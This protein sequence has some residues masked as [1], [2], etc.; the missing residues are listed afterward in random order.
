MATILVVDDRA[1]N[2]AFLSTL[3]GYAGYTIVEA[4]DAD[5]GLAVALEHR[6]D[7]VIA[8]ILMPTTDGFD[9]VRQLR[10][11]P[12]IA[13]TR[14]IFYTATYV[15]DEARDLARAVGVEHLLTKPAEPQ[16]ILATVQSVLGTTPAMPVAAATERQFERDHQRLLL[17]K[18]TQ[19]VDELESINADLEH[20]VAERTAELAELTE[21]LRDMNRQ[22]DRL[23][24]IVA[25]DLRSPLGSIQLMADELLE[26]GVDLPEMPHRRFLEQIRRQTAHLSHLISNLLN[27]QRI[28]SGQIALERMPVRASDI[29]RDTL[30]SLAASMSSKQITCRLEV[31]HDEPLIEADPLRLAQI[32][33]NLLGNAI[34]FTPAGGRITISLAA[35]PDE[36]LIRFADSGC[37]I[38]SDHLEF[39]FERFSRVQRKGTA[40]EPGSGLGLAI[41]QLLV[42][43]HGGA[44]SVQSVID[45]GTTFT[46]RL[47]IQAE[48]PGRSL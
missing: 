12:E 5:E 21:R 48:P 32:F 20:R 43:L 36:V 14:T 41:V 22:K 42:E 34:K 6:P 19:K 25:H 26:T 24:S 33:S 7:L 3:L 39:L 1:D 40:G 47:P 13:Q 28:E 37:G 29:L 11:C 10:A 9:F 2:R 8:D 30:T 31:E 15:A 23:L 38:P 27:L 44:I 35:E 4:S 46:L 17:D 45:E 16:E 18:L